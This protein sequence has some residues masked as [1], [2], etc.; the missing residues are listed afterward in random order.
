MFTLHIANR[1]Y[2]EWHLENKTTEVQI[3][4]LERK[5]FHGDILNENGELVTSPYR[6]K[7]DI[8]GVI[9]TSEKTYGRDGNKLLYKCVPDDEHL[10]CFLIPYEE[11]HIGFAKIKTDNYVAFRIKE[12]L[13][14]KHPIGIL[15]NTFGLVNDNEAYIAYKMSCKEINDSLK[16]LNAATLRALREKSL[17]PIPL[18][19]SNQ[20]IED[21]R[22]YPIISIDPPGCQ[23]IDDAL[24]LR[25]TSNGET[26]LSIYIANVPMM[27]EYLQLWPY[28]TDRISTLYLPNKKYPMLP[29]ALSENMF[30]L[31]EKE[32]RVAFVLDITLK[33]MSIQSISYASVIIN[34]EKNYA[35]ESSELLARPDYKQ[36]LEI[37][38]ELN[39]NFRYVGQITNSH[40]AVEYCMLF[41][42]RECAKRLETKKC[43]I[44]RSASKK[45]IPAELKHVLLGVAGEYCSFENKK[46]HEL[47]GVD[48]YVH[49]TS[50]IRRLVD[51][52]NMLTLL[53]DQVEWSDEAKQFIDK[54]Q[55]NIP[56]INKKTKAIRKLQNEMELLTMYEKQPDRTYMGIIFNKTSKNDVYKYTVYIQETKML[57]TVKS[58]KEFNNFT[59]A[60]FSAHLFLDEAKMTKKIRLQII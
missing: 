50:P 24:G 59:T 11:K 57:T 60:Y 21:R 58:Q 7:T 16:H 5:L 8:C 10:P 54:W 34:V 35:Y 38:K 6:K 22:S 4:P 15:T 36:I 37:V 14:T 18:Y 17:G 9:L 25:T 32:D 48:S 19:C 40:D 51:V 52:V 44:F 28:L 3:S 12:W 13:A 23:D 43:G 31:K 45:E 42:N 20:A 47:I 30:S 29:P 49:I 26:V 2:T 56:N 53:N 55:N 46:P 33:C 41:M 39:Y 1:D 27:L